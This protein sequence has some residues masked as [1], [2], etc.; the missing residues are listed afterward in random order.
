LGGYD[1]AGNGMYFVTIDIQDKLK[2]FWDDILLINKGGH[3]G[4]PV[5]E[6]NSCLHEINSCLHEINS[7]LHE[8]NIIGELIEYWWC[9]IPNHFNGVGIDEF[10]VMPDHI[11]G[12]II[13]NNGVGADRCVRPLGNVIQWFK[14]MT[15]NEY[16]RK[17][18]LDNW[19]QFNK[20]LWQ[21][22]YFERIIRNEREL[23]GI[24]KYIADNPVKYYVGAD[25]CV[26]PIDNSNEN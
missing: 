21:R 4:P 7:C 15:T 24:R 13:I 20:R 19:P 25:R 6:I 18:K 2:L 17:V 22:N 26:R 5:H 10:V 11:H 23:N 8:I 14:T 3:I 9:E 16:I 12:I 1:Y